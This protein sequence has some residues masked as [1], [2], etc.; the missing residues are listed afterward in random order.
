VPIIAMCSRE[1]IDWENDDVY[2]INVRDMMDEEDGFDM[3]TRIDDGLT[4]NT[5]SFESE[6]R[7]SMIKD[8]KKAAL[9][10]EETQKDFFKGLKDERLEALL[11]KYIDT[12]MS[13][14]PGLAGIPKRPE[15]MAIDLKPGAVVKD[16]P[17]RRFTNSE[18]IEVNSKVTELM[19]KEFVR[20]SSSPFN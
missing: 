10:S 1:D 13:E 6:P 15:D 5:M 12:V 14:P 17:M 8:D 9:S 7:I 11:R 4:I 3:P 18:D 2:A 19:G 16:R 20:P